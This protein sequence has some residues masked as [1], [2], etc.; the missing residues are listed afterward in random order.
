MK[1]KTDAAEE[2]DD[3]ILTSSAKRAREINWFQE[4]TKVVTVQD[5]LEFGEPEDINKMIK[6][7]EKEL[8]EKKDNREINRVLEWVNSRALDLFEKSLYEGGDKQ[9]SNKSKQKRNNIFIICITITITV[10]CIIIII[11][12]F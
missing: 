10:I 1:D 6:E 3:V 9:K 4:K 11:N 12:P 2:D 8:I 5:A 7:L